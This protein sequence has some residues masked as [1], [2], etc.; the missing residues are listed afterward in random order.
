MVSNSAIDR[1]GLIC[2]AT[3]RAV[4]VDNP[5]CRHWLSVFLIKMALATWS[6]SARNCARL[7]A[8]VE[9]SPIL[10]FESSAVLNMLTNA[11][12]QPVT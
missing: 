2:F 9:L 12:C 6:G 5:P 11:L 1:A 3:A 4:A 10:L 8:S 7:R